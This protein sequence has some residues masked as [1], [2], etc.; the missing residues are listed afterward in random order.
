MLFLQISWGS[1]GKDFF[2]FEIYYCQNLL[3]HLFATVSCAI[4]ENDI[5]CSSKENP[6]G[7]SARIGASFGTPLRLMNNRNN[8]LD[9]R[10]VKFYKVRKIFLSI[11]DKTNKDY[12]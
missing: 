8:N 2:L 12:L 6:R 1:R 11:S 3:G 9:M 10:N 5:L 7:E 4:T